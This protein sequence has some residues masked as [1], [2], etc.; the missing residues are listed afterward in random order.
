MA[1]TGEVRPRS[2]APERPTVQEKVSTP[3]Q[4]VLAA[5]TLGALED[6]APSQ[7]ATEEEEK[8]A[9][10]ERLAE[11]LDTDELARRVY[12]EV[13]RRVEVEWERRRR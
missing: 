6:T 4:R 11:A 1:G 12:S 9:R 3:V 2:P 7:P 10:G 5:E 8:E 13:R